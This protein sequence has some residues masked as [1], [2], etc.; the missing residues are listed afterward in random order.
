MS[1]SEG[2]LFS[3]SNAV[4]YYMIE[5]A[6]KMRK[7]SAHPVNTQRYKPF[8]D[9]SGPTIPQNLLICQYPSK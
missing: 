4:K 7:F 1:D 8:I 2:E 5:I 6:G 9:P 3:I